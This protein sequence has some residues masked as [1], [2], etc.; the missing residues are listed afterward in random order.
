VVIEDRL[1]LISQDIVA[2]AP[3]LLDQLLRSTSEP[4]VV[5]LLVAAHQRLHEVTTSHT[6]FLPTRQ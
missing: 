3:L 4:S 2:L 6:S 1:E 5:T